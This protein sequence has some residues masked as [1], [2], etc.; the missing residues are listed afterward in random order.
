MLN[1]SLQMVRG[2]VSVYSVKFVH[3]ITDWLKYESWN[4][5]HNSVLSHLAKT[6]H[7]PVRHK[8]RRCWP[9]RCH[10]V[11]LWRS[12]PEA[13]SCYGRFAADARPIYMLIASVCARPT[14]LPPHPGS[15]G[16]F[17]SLII[18]VLAA[19]TLIIFS[20]RLVAVEHQQAPI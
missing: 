13:A 1:G 15:W 20:K 16:H 2:W 9:V 10:H 17:F 11:M 14:L 5:S 3:L 4:Y 8:L 12:Q 19:I 18:Y 7:M 6:H